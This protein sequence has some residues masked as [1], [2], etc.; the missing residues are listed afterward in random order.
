MLFSAGVAKLVGY[1][2]EAARDHL[3]HHLEEL[4]LKETKTEENRADKW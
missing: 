4:L 3:C 1:K 2:R